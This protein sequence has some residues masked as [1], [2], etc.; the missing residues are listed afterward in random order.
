M[1]VK[2]IQTQSENK[3]MNWDE[4]FFNMISYI[5]LK[6]KDISTKVGSI[7]VS[8]DNEI[9]STGFNGFPRGVIDS[10]DE[11]PDRYQRDIKLLFTEHAE[12][13]SI[14][15]AAKRG[16]ALEGSKIY[17]EWSPCADCM[18]AIIQSGIKEVILNG[19]S[20]DFNNQ[21][22]NE[23]WKDHIEC[24]TIMAQEAGIKIRIYKD[25]Q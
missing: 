15:A 13:N 1:I 14:Y 24:A 18:R 16:T 25:V 21:K 4:Y 23:R 20:T 10:L 7:I 8:K 12:R 3:I 2:P 9:I 22:L 11:V 5:K 19:T 6:S 17:V